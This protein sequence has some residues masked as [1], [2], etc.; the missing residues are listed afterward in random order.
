VEAFGCK[1]M[2]QA[3]KQASKA[4]KQTVPKEENT[5]ETNNDKI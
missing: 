4:S 5:I 3:S 1:S 2:L